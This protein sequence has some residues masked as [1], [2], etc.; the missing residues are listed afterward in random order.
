MGPQTLRARESK[1]KQLAIWGYLGPA[2][3]QAQHLRPDI[4]V[5]HFVYSYMYVP[6]PADFSL[7]QPGKR[8]ELSIVWLLRALTWVPGKA[9]S[10]VC[11]YLS[12]WLCVYCAC[13]SLCV[14]ILTHLCLRSLHAQPHHWQDLRIKSHSS[15]T[16]TKLL[17]SP[18]SNRCEH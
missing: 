6:P 5:I 7:N 10:F 12:G 16:S 13:V 3:S 8:T 4:G 15:F 2:T 17:Y 11:I 1:W 14:Y 9:F 18:A